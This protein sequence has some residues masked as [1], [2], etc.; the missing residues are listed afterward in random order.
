MINL[1]FETWHIMV[2]SLNFKKMCVQ[3]FMFSED[4]IILYLWNNKVWNQIKKL[5]SD[6]WLKDRNWLYNSFFLLQDFNTGILIEFQQCTS[7]FPSKNRKKIDSSFLRE[8]EFWL[9]LKKKK[10][11]EKKKI[12][13][14]MKMPR[15][16]WEWNSLYV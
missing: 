9:S 12:L 3:L 16:I 6:N 10:K 2:F 13:F 14:T 4:K 1:L 11:K 5:T 7:F 8:I 15:L